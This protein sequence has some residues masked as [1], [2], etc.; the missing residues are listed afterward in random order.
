M[1]RYIWLAIVILSCLVALYLTWAGSAV[2]NTLILATG[3]VTLALWFA[4][5]KRP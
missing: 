5:S 3:A 4:E 2:G 1:G